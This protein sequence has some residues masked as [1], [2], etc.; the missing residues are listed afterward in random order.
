MRFISIILILFFGQ[1]VAHAQKI[2]E[3]AEVAKK[4]FDY[5]SIDSL[6]GDDYIAL[7]DLDLNSTSKKTLMNDLDLSAQDT[8]NLFDFKHYMFEYGERYLNKVFNHPKIEKYSL[9]ELFGENYFTISPDNKLAVLTIPENNGGSYQSNWSFLH[10]RNNDVKLS[11][12][13]EEINEYMSDGFYSIDQFEVN[14]VVYYVLLGSVRT[15][16][17]CYSEYINVI[18]FQEDLLTSVFDY[19]VDG[20]YFGGSSAISLSDNLD[21]LYIAEGPSMSDYLCDDFHMDQD[22]L[23]EAENTVMVYCYYTYF[24]NGETYAIAEKKVKYIYE[25]N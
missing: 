18:Y 13:T 20:Y 22:E 3:L 1:N 16:T 14:N 5:A 10:F 25:K 23:S 24:F 19:V 2:K 12:K 21:S 4:F 15:C 17:S 9:D 7:S 11:I 8:I 6:I